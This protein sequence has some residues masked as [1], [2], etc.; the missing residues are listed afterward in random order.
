MNIGDIY[1]DYFGRE[2]ECVTGGTPPP[3][4]FNKDNVVNGKIV[5]GTLEFVPKS[6]VTTLWEGNQ[7]STGSAQ[8]QFTVNL[9]D[10]YNNYDKL[11]FYITVKT[12]DLL[13]RPIY[14]EITTDIVAQYAG[15]TSLITSLNFNW[16][17]GSANDYMDIVI[18]D[19]TNTSFKFAC[20]YSY[21]T[22]IV[23]IKYPQSQK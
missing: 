2:Y 16:G 13:T 1:T 23:G 10:N 17:Y 19:I 20:Y 21:L 11:G 14:R 22:K 3:Q 5:W 18:A 4:P 8:Y 6:I 9:S 12:S 7:G 15:F